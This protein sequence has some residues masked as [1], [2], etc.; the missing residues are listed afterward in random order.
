MLSN[1]RKVIMITSTKRFT[2]N[3]NIDTIMNSCIHFC[4]IFAGSRFPHLHAEVTYPKA[5]SGVNHCEKAGDKNV[6]K[7]NQYLSNG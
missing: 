5:Y 7:C 6:F 4:Q 1:M 2:I 3:I